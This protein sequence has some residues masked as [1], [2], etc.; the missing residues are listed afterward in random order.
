[1]PVPGFLES[2]STDFAVNTGA[3][4]VS[5]PFLARHLPTA[6][7]VRVET[8]ADVS[9]TAD[10]IP[11][12]CDLSS[13]TFLSI[14]R[15]KVW[16]KPISASTHWPSPMTSS[17]T[18]AKRIFPEEDWAYFRL[19]ACSCL[20]I[21]RTEV[22]TA[23]NHL[24]DRSR[25]NSRG[26]E[27]TPDSLREVR[28]SGN[29]RTSWVSCSLFL[30]LLRFNVLFVRDGFA[31]FCVVGTT[32][33]RVEESTFQRLDDNS[34]VIIR[35]K[36][37]F[38]T[39]NRI[40]DYPIRSTSTLLTSTTFCNLDPRRQKERNF[41]GLTTLIVKAYQNLDYNASSNGFDGNNMGISRCGLQ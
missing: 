15:V 10:K 8:G 36:R 3:D 30:L 29:F 18:T 17:T 25:A 28:W 7:T 35:S 1:M 21:F 13:S 6:P 24:R 22:A 4:T 31:V 33:S 9:L 11:R 20:P 32:T 26:D 27:K 14:W 23:P 37:N 5:L 19:I 41:N 39:K 2:F 34:L 12:L 16:D 40:F 38:T